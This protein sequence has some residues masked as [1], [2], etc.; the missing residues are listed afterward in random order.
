MSF[1][2]HGSLHSNRTLNKNLP[3]KSRTLGS[4]SQYYIKYKIKSTTLFGS[5]AF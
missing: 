4:S 5:L 1:C 2:G 3:N